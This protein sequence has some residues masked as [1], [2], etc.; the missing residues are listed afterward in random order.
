[1]KWLVKALEDF[2]WLFQLGLSIV[3]PLLLCLAA[4]WWLTTR[5]GWP[6]WIFIP[7]CLAGIGGS[8]VAFRNF[9]RMIIKRFRNDS[10]RS[11]SYNRHE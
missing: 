1:M 6:D 4:C 11:S 10:R 3:M 5:R 7:G 2:T 8:A 9:A